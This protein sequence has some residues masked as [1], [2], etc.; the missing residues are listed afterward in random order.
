[1]EDELV[2]REHCYILYGS[3]VLCVFVVMV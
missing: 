1:M 3:F 2:Y